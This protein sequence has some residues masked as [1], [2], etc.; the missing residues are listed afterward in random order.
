[1]ISKPEGKVRLRVSEVE[2][3]KNKLRRVRGEEKK[4]RGNYAVGCFVI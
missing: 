4:S 1:L 3:L 2:M